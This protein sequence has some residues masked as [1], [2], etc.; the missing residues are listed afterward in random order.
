MKSLVQVALVLLVVA[1][2]SPTFGWN[3]PYV[4][5]RPHVTVYS[6][7]YVVPHKPVVIHTYK[8]DDDHDDRKKR[9]AP[10]EAAAARQKRSADID[11]DDLWWYRPPV[12]HTVY[13]KPVVPAVTTVVARPYYNPGHYVVGHG[14]YDDK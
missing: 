1:L 8:L 12:S 13:T 10:E 11:L 6:R 5:G 14:Y 3:V 4:Y 9:S 2:A 7:P